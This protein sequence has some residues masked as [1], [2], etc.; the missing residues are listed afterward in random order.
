MGFGLTYV[1]LVVI[2][3][4]LV[5]E[6]LDEHQSDTRKR[7]PLPAFCARSSVAWWVGS[8]TKHIGAR[9]LFLDRAAGIVGGDIAIVWVSTATL[10]GPATE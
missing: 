3:G 5:P 6:R 10:A 2:T 1:T 8:S 7:H 9:Q 4:T